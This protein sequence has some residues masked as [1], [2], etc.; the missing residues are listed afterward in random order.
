MSPTIDGIDGLLA[1]LTAPA[2]SE[3]DGE[4]VSITQHGLQCAA[5]LRARHPDD[6]ALQVAGLVHDVGTVL[7]PARPATHAAT[8]ARALRPLLGDRVAALVGDHDLAKRYLVTVDASYRSRLSPRSIETLDD[9]GGLLDASARAEFEAAP[10]FDGCLALRRAD[11]AAKVPH[12]DAGTVD[13]WRAVIERVARVHSADR[14]P[15]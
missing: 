11:D 8:G 12:L 4:P 6:E 15:G 14:A 1:L 2:A 9:Q 5:I 7:A 3:H 10:H 13:E